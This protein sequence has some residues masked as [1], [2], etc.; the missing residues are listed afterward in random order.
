VFKYARRHRFLRHL[1]K[2]RITAMEL[3]RR[4]DAGDRLAIVDL[5][6]DL[7]IQTVPDLSRNAAEFGP[8]D[9]TSQRGGLLL[10]GAQRGNERPDRPP[11]RL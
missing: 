3:K 5:R 11:P 1:R 7:D 8:P 4:L 10:R 6:T 9:P 2:A